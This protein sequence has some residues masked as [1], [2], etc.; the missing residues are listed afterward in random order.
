MWGVQWISKAK[1]YISLAKSYIDIDIL[2]ATNDVDRDNSLAKNYI[3]RDIS[4][5][6]ISCLKCI[7]TGIL[8][9]AENNIDR[10]TL[11]SLN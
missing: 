6:N 9:L 11:F 2:L 3:D 7:L 4:E 1:L 10:E 8:S 5:F